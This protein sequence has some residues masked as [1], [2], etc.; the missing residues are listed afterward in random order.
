MLKIPVYILINIVS[1]DTIVISG[2][3]SEMILLNI[4]ILKVNI[5]ITKYDNIFTIG[6][7]D[8]G[9]VNSNIE[10]DKEVNIIYKTF[11]FLLAVIFNIKVKNNIVIVNSIIEK[12]TEKILINPSFGVVKAVSSVCKISII[13]QNL[14]KIIFILWTN[15]AF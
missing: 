7:I 10:Q 12:G 2:T 1:N 11:C 4:L 8:V 5:I 3:N 13:I 14:H 6:E 15:I 9:K